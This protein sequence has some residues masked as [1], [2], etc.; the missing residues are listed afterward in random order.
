MGTQELLWEY[1]VPGWAP[2]SVGNGVVVVRSWVQV[3]CLDAIT[4][5]VLWTLPEMILAITA[6]TVMLLTVLVLRRVKSRT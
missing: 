4:G 3:D 2:L 5:E 1:E 6:I